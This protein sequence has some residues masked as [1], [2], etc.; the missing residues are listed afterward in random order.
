MK[1]AMGVNIKFEKKF[2]FL[3][4]KYGKKSAAVILG[5]LSNRSKPSASF[6]AADEPIETYNKNNSTAMTA[7]SST[8]IL[9]KSTGF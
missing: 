5:F 9:M 4:L 3:F 8:K 1:I 7:I 2:N 6:L